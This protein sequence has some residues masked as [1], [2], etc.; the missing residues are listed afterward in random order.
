MQQIAERSLVVAI[1]GGIL[2]LSE[3]VAHPRVVTKIL[4]LLTFMTY[5]IKVR[6]NG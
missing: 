5:L 3:E 4:K 1:A 6:P 2:D